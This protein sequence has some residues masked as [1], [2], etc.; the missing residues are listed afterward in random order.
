MPSARIIE[1]YVH[2]LGVWLILGALAFAPLISGCA[3]VVLGGAAVGAAAVHDRRDYTDML[4]D[5]E[6]ELRAGAALRGDKSLSGRG[7]ISVTSYNHTVLLTGQAETEAVATRAAGLVSRLPKVERVVD[8][9]TIGPPISL[10]QES[11]DVFLTSRSKLAMTKIKLPGFDAT[12]V[13]VVTEDA[14]VF[15][16]GLVSSEEAD[17]A[18]E[19]VRYVPGVK[20]V[21]KLFE[22]REPQ[23]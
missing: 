4:D 12:R 7:R 3:A 6:I 23:G 21:V 19:Q 18:A 10:M 2:G 15:L 5:E 11:Q 14:V 17:A 16:M 22:Y 8:E 1:T 9:V 13:K 20:R